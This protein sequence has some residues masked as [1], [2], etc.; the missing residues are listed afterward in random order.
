MIFAIGYL[1]LQNLS[2]KIEKTIQTGWFPPYLEYY[3]A[4]KKIQDHENYSILKIQEELRLRNYIQQESIQKIKLGEFILLENSDCLQLQSYSDGDCILWMNKD[5]PHNKNIASVQNQKLK[6]YQGSPFKSVSFVLLDPILLAQREGE[7]LHFRKRFKLNSAPYFCL[8]SITTSEDENF[9]LHKGISLTGIARAFIQNI[10]K[11][12]ITQGGS[13]I[14]QQLIKN[15][16]L[17]SEKSFRRKWTELLMSLILERKLNKDQIL[18]LYMNTVYMGGTGSYSLYGFASASQYYFNKPLNHMSLPECAL[19]TSIIPSPG[20][21][22]PFSFPEKSKSK[23][24]LILKKMKAQN[25]ISLNNLNDALATPL[26]QQR[27]SLQ[28]HKASYFV[29]AVHKEIQNLNIDWRDNLKIYTTMDITAHQHARKSL[30]QTLNRLEKEKKPLEG[31]LIFVEVETNKV[32]A[33]IGG[34]NFIHSPFNRAIEA[35]RP[36]G[37]LVKPWVY[38]SALIHNNINPLTLVQDEPLTFKKWSPKNYDNK[39]FRSVPLYFALKESLNSASVRV[40]LDVGLK[41]IILT[42]KKLGFH[43][44]VKP[45]PSLTLG[46]LELSLLEVMQMYSTIARMGSYKKLSLIDRIE[47]TN[48]EILYENLNSS[49]QVLPEEKTAVLIGMM[50]QVVESGTAHWIKSF[51]PY[52]TAGKTGTTN[53]E[54]DSWFVGFTPQY[55]TGVWIG[56]DDNTPH[57]LTGSSGALVAWLQFMKKFNLSFYDFQWPP[58][59]ESRSVALPIINK[60]KTLKEV[61]FFKLEPSDDSLEPSQAELIFESAP[62]KKWY[63]FF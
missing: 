60:D 1:I 50:K 21:F 57:K 19:L 41:N 5:F 10:L 11:A 42:F 20:R 63:K 7:L 48:G 43:S 54:R 8:Q 30:N 2:Y 58:N 59:T 38:L 47:N 51:W 18:E 52:V 53:Q 25:K 13:T 40:G 22:N 29:N 24:D 49:E 61:Q 15:R 39:Y 12:K 34:S 45:L 56:Y 3:S 27:T 35:Q 28:N 37:S 36:I 33:L 31:A 62:H 9:I 6:L 14:T 23:R 55:L 32:R 26:P 17:T 46:A 16:F 4:P 44:P